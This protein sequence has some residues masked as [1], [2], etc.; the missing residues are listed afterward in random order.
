[1]SVQFTVLRHFDTVEAAQ[2]VRTYLEDNGIS[3]QVFQE[4]ARPEPSQ[5]SFVV[6]VPTG[7]FER[8]EALLRDHLPMEDVEAMKTLDEWEQDHPDIGE[9]YEQSDYSRK[10]K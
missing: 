1:M 10:M 2:S 4:A 5:R 8:A 3:P 9:R 7:D 6:Q